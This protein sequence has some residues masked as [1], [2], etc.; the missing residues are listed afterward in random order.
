MVVHGTEVIQSLHSA[1]LPFYFGMGRTACST[2][3]LQAAA[4]WIL[5]LPSLHA[6]SYHLIY[7]FNIA[8]HWEGICTDLLIISLQGHSKDA[9]ILY[10]RLEPAIPLC[11]ITTH[12]AF[13]SCF[14]AQ[15]LSLTWSFCST[16]SKSTDCLGYGSTLLLFSFPAF[17]KRFY[18]TLV[19]LFPSLPFLSH[20]CFSVW[21]K[22]LKIP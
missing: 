2:Q 1:F 16:A 9:I 20:F 10:V 22:R 4:E 17:S 8:E 5:A 18:V 19:L 7:F 6:S 13:T 14:T 3:Q 15:T 12:Q 11:I 21:L